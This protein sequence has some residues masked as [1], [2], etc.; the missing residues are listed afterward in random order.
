MGLDLHEKE[1]FDM[2][3]KR[4]YKHTDMDFPPG[5]LVKKDNPALQEE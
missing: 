1:L 5:T 3:F 2:Q 4:I